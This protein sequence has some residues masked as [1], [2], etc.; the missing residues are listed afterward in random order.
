MN[1]ISS[2]YPFISQLNSNADGY[3]T[4]F[5]SVEATHIGNSSSSSKNLSRHAAKLKIKTG[6]AAKFKF[7]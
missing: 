6:G 3:E 7:S 4:N 2:T 5:F 1:V